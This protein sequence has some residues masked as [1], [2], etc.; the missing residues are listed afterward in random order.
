VAQ[1]LMTMLPKSSVGAEEGRTKKCSQRWARGRGIFSLTSPLPDSESSLQ[2]KSFS[3]ES[4]PPSISS[5]FG[6]PR[7]RERVI[8]PVRCPD[9]VEILRPC[10]R[11]R[12][13][14]MEVCLARSRAARLVALL[15]PG[16]FMQVCLAPEGQ[17]KISR[18]INSG[19]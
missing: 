5:I 14:F 18:F 15:N 11:S 10:P 3:T 2:N 1:L 4:E 8:Y 9:E 13:L 19:C 6:R 16:P 12:R 7:C 17:G